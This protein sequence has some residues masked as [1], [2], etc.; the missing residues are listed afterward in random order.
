MLDTLTIAQR[1]QEAGVDEPQAKAITEAVK[2][3]AERGHSVTRD[4]LRSELALVRAEI[5]G[6]GATLTW[7]TIGVVGLGVAVIRLWN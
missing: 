2:E 5:A 4:M 3:A 7:P 1:L 6:L